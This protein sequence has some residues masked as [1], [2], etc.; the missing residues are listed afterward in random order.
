[1]PDS[2]LIESVQDM[3]RTYPRNVMAARLAD[4]IYRRDDLKARGNNSHESLSR[5]IEEIER[6]F[7]RLPPNAKWLIT[8]GM[9][10]PEQYKG[11]VF[12]Y[13]SFAQARQDNDALVGKVTMAEYVGDGSMDK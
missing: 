12:I 3:V 5:I 4:Y 1:M 10:S 8:T 7:G 13:D 2:K 11:R 9:H 6:Q